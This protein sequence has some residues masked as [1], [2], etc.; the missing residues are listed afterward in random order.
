MTRL[1]AARRAASPVAVVAPRVRH[2]REPA[3]RAARRAFAAPPAPSAVAQ[4]RFR[5]GRDVPCRAGVAASPRDSRPLAFSVARAWRVRL[6]DLAT[7]R[8]ARSVALPRSDAN[9]GAAGDIAR[10]RVAISSSFLLLA[11]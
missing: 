3:S 4:P 10:S 9:L 5:A 7:G 6:R 11:T 2:V 8:V 1:G